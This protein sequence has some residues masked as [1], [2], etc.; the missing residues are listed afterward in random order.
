[1]F[2][3][4]GFDINPCTSL[5]TDLY[6]E[7]QICLSITF[8]GCGFIF[9]SAINLLILHFQN[10]SVSIYNTIPFTMAYWALFSHVHRAVMESR[11]HNPRPRVRDLIIRDRDR[12]LTIRDRDHPFR[13]RDL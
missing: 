1:M 12:D 8:G 9:L 3:F 10:W 4:F 7:F 11:P 6:L 13:D 2:I 5:L